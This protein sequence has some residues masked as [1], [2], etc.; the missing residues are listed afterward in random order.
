MDLNQTSSRAVINWNTF[1][2]GS[3]AQVDYKLDAWFEKEGSSN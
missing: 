1:N 3:Q 2:V